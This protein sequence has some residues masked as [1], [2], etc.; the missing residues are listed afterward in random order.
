MRSPALLREEQTWDGKEG[1][2]EFS[3]RQNYRF[4]MKLRFEK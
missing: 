2:G 4:S 1:T 3:Y